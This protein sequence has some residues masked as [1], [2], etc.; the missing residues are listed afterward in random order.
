ED[1]EKKRA[2]RFEKSSIHEP[3][4]DTDGNPKSPEPRRN[5]P[6]QTW[7]CLAKSLTE[8]SGDVR[9]LADTLTK[10]DQVGD[11]VNNSGNHLSHVVVEVLKSSR[12]LGLVNH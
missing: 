7:T 10:G 6:T 1:K 3:V 5:S 9:T 11:E 4:V 12:G 2:P 8:P